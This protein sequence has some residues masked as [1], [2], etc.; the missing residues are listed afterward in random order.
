[1]AEAGNLAFAKH[2]CTIHLSRAIA[3]TSSRSIG[4]GSKIG[5][6]VRAPIIVPAR[7]PSVTD[8]GTS[9]HPGSSLLLPRR[10]MTHRGSRY[11]NGDATGA[12]RLGP[13]P[14]L[15]PLQDALCLAALELSAVLR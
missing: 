8:S 14:A 15:H 1:M 11:T 2:V 6:G 7:F 4:S 9:G 10:W 3:L 13:F 5:E 12:D